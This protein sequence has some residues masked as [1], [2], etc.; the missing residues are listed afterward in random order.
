MQSKFYL[1]PVKLDVIKSKELVEKL[2]TPLQYECFCEYLKATFNSVR[3]YRDTNYYF[4]KFLKSSAGDYAIAEHVVNQIL[5][6]KKSLDNEV[7]W[8]NNN[9]INMISEICMLH[10]KSSLLT[11]KQIQVCFPLELRSVIKTRENDST[12]LKIIHKQKEISKNTDQK[13]KRDNDILL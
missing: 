2:C 7:E 9:A 5:E 4:N 1:K 12:K 13:L 10:E 3:N 11:S 6:L 8:Q